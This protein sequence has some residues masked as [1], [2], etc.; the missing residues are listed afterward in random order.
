MPRTSIDLP[1]EVSYLSILNAEGELDAD[2]E[3]DISD[4]LL[5]RM[6]RAMVFSRK[7]DERMLDLQ[8]QGRIGTFAPV[9]GEEASQIGSAAALRDEDW[10]VQS[11]RDQAA[12]MYRGIP[13]ESYMVNYAGYY[14]GNKGG[15]EVNT[16]P[17]AVPVGSQPL[18][19]V[20]IAYGAKYRKTD[21]VVLVF[22]GDGATSEGDFHEAA[23]FAGVFRT[24]TIFLC[25]NNHWAISVPRERQ[26]RSKT[27]AQKALAYGIEG[28]QVDGN[29]VLAV[30]Q[31]TLEAAQ[32]ARNGDGPTVVEAVTYRMSLHTTADDP[33]RYRSDDEVEEW[34]RRDPIRRFETYL[35]E[36]DLLSEEDSD[37]VRH[38]VES[39]IEE[40]VEKTEARMEELS[41]EALSMFD[42]MYAENPPY[43]RKQRE[44]LEAELSRRGG[45]DV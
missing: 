28:I 14:Q 35:K 30:Y 24:P 37:S 33:S 6:H 1:N 17:V 18:H 41:G 39:E 13:A 4:E 45:S 36:K 11:Y 7:I 20:G 19:A 9:R 29:D 40:V 10:M 25:R 38:D 21:Q 5:K 44:E 8:R 15:A 31:A 42:H 43:L 27:I 12:G 34:E 3:P 2:L 16:L 32:R 23:N 22:F 26:T